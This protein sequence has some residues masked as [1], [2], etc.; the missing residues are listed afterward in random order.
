MSSV[1]Y[2]HV[3]FVMALGKQNA[4]H[5]PWY[6]L[7]TPAAMSAASPEFPF[8]PLRAVK[9]TTEDADGKAKDKTKA[10]ASKET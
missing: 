3:F 6:D 7:K 9:Q 8:S 1:N 4:S 2:I 10:P 5:P